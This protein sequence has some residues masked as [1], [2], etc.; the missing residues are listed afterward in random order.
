MSHQ[1]PLVIF[2]VSLDLVV[3]NTFSFF[4]IWL[5]G[6]LGVWYCTIVHIKFVLGNFAPSQAFIS[7]LVALA[8][9]HINNWL[10][11]SFFMLYLLKDI[12]L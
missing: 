1:K 4:K 2:I 6:S 10:N 3:I 11:A 8:L 9:I 7:K 12:I 5:V